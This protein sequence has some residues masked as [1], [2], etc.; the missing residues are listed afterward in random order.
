MVIIMKKKFGHFFLELCCSYTLV[1]VI[2]AVVNIIGGTETNNVNVIMMFVF[3]V[4]ACIVL[5]LH[6]LFDSLSPLLM[7][8]V[9]Y[10]I[11]VALVFGAVNVFRLI[12]QETLTRKNWFELFRSFTIPYFIGAG[13]YYYGIYSEAKAQNRIIK[14]LQ[15]AGGEDR[16]KG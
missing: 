15:R 13:L 9:Q 10:M 1:S 4:I 2:G 11:A 6:K 8:V 7:I 5:N 3:C 16:D 12:L 14:E